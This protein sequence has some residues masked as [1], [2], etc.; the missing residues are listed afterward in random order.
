[1][2]NYVPNPSVTSL[3]SPSQ[4]LPP[5]FAFNVDN[6][7]YYCHQVTV[8]SLSQI[9]REKAVEFK[10]KGQ[11]FN[12]F[13]DLKNI[14]DPKRY[15]QLI[16]DYFHGKN[17]QISHENA[18]FLNKIASILGLSNLLKSTE[19]YLAPLS[20]ENAIEQMKLYSESGVEYYKCADLIASQ[21]N[22]LKNDPKV[23]D[24]PVFAFEQIFDSESLQ[25]DSE[26][27]LISYIKRLIA[28]HG[29]EYSILFKSIHTEE[30]SQNEIDDILSHTEVDTID[31][32]IIDSLK[33]RLVL[34]I[35]VPEEDEVDQNNIPNNPNTAY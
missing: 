6:K 17:I 13:N 27:S 30:I 4:S 28:V 23:F 21:W 11:V 8:F 35:Y 19:Q 5:D 1:M 14:R 15:F 31:P 20:Y 18:P 12:E 22:V 10:E 33:E 24:L 7:I 16:C 29:D 25:I 26:S 9:L 32:E 34:D 2:L 3:F